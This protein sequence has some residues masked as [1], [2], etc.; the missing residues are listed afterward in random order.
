MGYETRITE[1]ETSKSLVEQLLDES[2]RVIEDL[3]MTNS[4]FQNQIL[5]SEQK[6]RALERENS[7]SKSRNKDLT[8]ENCEL[9]KQVSEYQSKVE[10]LVGKNSKLAEQ[11]P[12]YSKLK[13]EFDEMSSTIELLQSDSGKWKELEEE[14]EKANLERMNLHNEVTKLRE[15]KS[16]FEAE[17]Q[18]KKIDF[19]VYQKKSLGESSK[20]N[21]D[22]DEARQEVDKLSKDLVNCKLENNRLVKHIENED[23]KLKKANAAHIRAT[24]E[25]QMSRQQLDRLKGE[26]ESKERDIEHQ[27]N[28]IKNTTNDLCAIRTVKHSL[29]TILQSKSAELNGLKVDVELTDLQIKQLEKEVNLLK[30]PSEFFFAIKNILETI[31]QQDSSFCETNDKWDKLN[32]MSDDEIHKVVISMLEDYVESTKRFKTELDRMNLVINKMA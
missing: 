27:K 23:A 30:S 22:L 2:N 12:T 21:K 18:K 20:L 11:I 26:N 28:V 16:E 7:E 25:L 6:L 8:E 31:F 17:F 3:K 24:N 10:Y 32:M 1:V 4:V 14:L 19:T 13:S 9:Q 15:N 29:E 5:E